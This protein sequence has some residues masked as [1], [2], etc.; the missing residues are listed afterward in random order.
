MADRDLKYL[1]RTYAWDVRRFLTSRVPS[2]D[3]AA[4]LTQETFIRFLR[5]EPATAIGDP[6][7]YL[8]KTAANLAID[9][10]R[11]SARERMMA[12]GDALLDTLPDPKPS[13]EAGV[14][15]REELSVLRRAIDDLSPRT[16][17]VFL[18]H[19]FEELTYQEI[20][21]QLGI[22]KNTVIVH[23]VRALAKLRQRL[24]HHRSRAS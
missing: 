10:H 15:A 20:A 24:H 3:I 2:P 21:I 16:R 12:G 11:S 5:A 7:A 14:L 19:K 22:S 6:R 1:F 23:M 13:A 9:H 8:L 17:E 4:D 18:L